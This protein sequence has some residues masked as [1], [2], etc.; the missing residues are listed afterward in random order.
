VC[1][2]KKTSS[3]ISSQG[4]PLE[5]MKNV[6]F[7]YK[8]MYFIEYEIKEPSNYDEAVCQHAWTLK[9]NNVGWV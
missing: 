3:K 1:A 9:N 7:H 4:P 2:F 8:N 6:L 5:R